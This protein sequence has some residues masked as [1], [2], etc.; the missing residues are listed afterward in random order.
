MNND[1]LEKNK[2][3]RMTKLQYDLLY[4]EAGEDERIISNVIRKAIDLYFEQK[5]LIDEI[6]DSE[7]R[8][9]DSTFKIIAAFSELDELDLIETKKRYIQSLR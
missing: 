6:R 1:K 9:I 4:A 2:N 7:Q 3:V 8:V 5:N